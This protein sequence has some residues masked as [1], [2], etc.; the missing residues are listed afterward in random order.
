M[1]CPGAAVI[2]RL[3]LELPPES[4]LGFEI[5]GRRLIVEG[6]PGHHTYWLVTYGVRRTDGGCRDDIVILRSLGMAEAYCR[7]SG[8]HV[9][10]V[11]R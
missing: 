3:S 5:S 9:I 4:L 11:K 8:L 1:L 10:E 6:A 7:L 2:R